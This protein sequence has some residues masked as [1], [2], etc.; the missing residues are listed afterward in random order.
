[1]FIPV[2]FIY[3]S[4]Y[5]KSPEELKADAELRAFNQQRENEKFE[6]KK[7]GEFCEFLRTKG[8]TPILKCNYGVRFIS[9]RYPNLWGEYDN[10]GN[11]NLIWWAQGVTYNY[12]IW[13]VE[14]R[15]Y[16]DTAVED[17]IRAVSADGIGGWVKPNVLYF[18]QPKENIAI[19]LERGN[20]ED[21]HKASEIIAHNGKFEWYTTEYKTGDRLEV[22]TLPKKHSV[23]FDNAMFMLT[24]GFVGNLKSVDLESYDI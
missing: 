24:N 18:R 13:E 19:D 6:K 8:F 11:V 10:G 12:K 4:T 9:D 21:M 17:I 7:R 5:Q 23:I 3:G 20:P 16:T 22:Y 14:F 1:M 2:P 15:Q